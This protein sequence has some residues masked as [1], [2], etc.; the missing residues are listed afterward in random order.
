[1]ENPSEWFL[2]QTTRTAAIG[3][4]AKPEETVNL[5]F[6]AKPRNPHS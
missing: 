5:G 3:F 4:E 1:M 2:G 6:E